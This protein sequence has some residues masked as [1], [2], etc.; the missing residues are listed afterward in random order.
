MLSKS[1]KPS[2]KDIAPYI[3]QAIQNGSDVRLTV[4]GFSMY[5]LLRGGSDDVVLTK[6]RSLKKYDVVLYKRENGDYVFHRIIKIKGESLIIAGD[7]ETK[8]EK[9]VSSS[10]VI[11]KMKSFIRS[12]KTHMSSA[13]WHQI[14][15]RIW[16]FIFPARHV[17]AGILHFLAKPAKKVMKAVDG[18]KKD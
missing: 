12:G 13:I 10:A 18:H 1:F 2:I 16:L 9:N 6:P 4:T 8:K 14:Y 17:A 15:C 3:E 5:P 7:N 11:A